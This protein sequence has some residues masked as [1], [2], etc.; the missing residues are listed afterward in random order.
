[1]IACAD[2]GFLVSL[3]GHDSQSAAATALVKSKPVF[4]LTLLGEAEF[5]NALQLQVFR[6]QWT[7]RQARMIQDQFVQ[8]QALGIFRSEPLDP[9]VWTKALLLSR[10]HSAKLGT[11]TLDVLHVA[12]ALVLHPDVFYSFDERQRKL[13]RAE[14]LRVLPA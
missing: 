11:R 4:L 7:R 13:A 1:M 8:H 2:T 6:G 9:E 5:T 12:A 14:R 3:Y 10:R